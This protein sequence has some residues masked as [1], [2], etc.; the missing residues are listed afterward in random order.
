VPE[1]AVD[2]PARRRR[3]LNL[4]RCSST[5]NFRPLF[6]NPQFWPLCQKLQLTTR[7]ST[8][9]PRFSLLFQYPQFSP[10]VAEFAILAAV[11]E[12]AVDVP[13]RRS[14]S[15]NLA[16]CSSTRNFRPLFQNPQPTSLVLE[17]AV[18]VPAHRRSSPTVTVPAL[19]AAVPEPAILAAVPEPAV[20]VPARRRRSLDLARCSSTR[21]FRP[22]FQNPQ[23]WPL[24]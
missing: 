4:A 3:S 17:P 16:R 1:P 12:P 18:D 20:D 19:L 22:L 24:C 11:L 23:F 8:Q 6:P 2:V 14:R 7:Q 15:L 13:A 9:K 21:N 10:A 5:R